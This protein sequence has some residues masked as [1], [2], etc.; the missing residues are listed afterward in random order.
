MEWEK[1]AEMRMWVGFRWVGLV[2]V[3]MGGGALSLG[4]VLFV[5]KKEIWV[6]EQKKNSFVCFGGE[7][8]MC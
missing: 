1:E 4:D 7:W 8:R 2:C 6:W 5:T 3:F